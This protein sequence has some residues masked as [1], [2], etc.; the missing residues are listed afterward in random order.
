VIY[1]LIAVCLLFVMGYIYGV[2]NQNRYYLT[3]PI[4]PLHYTSR[5]MMHATRLAEVKKLKDPLNGQP[6]GL[7]GLTI[8]EMAEFSGTLYAENGARVVGAA[9]FGDRA[10]LGERSYVGDG[11]HIG[12]YAWVGENSIVLAGAHIGSLAIIGS[13]TV[14]GENVVLPNGAYV[15]PDVVVPSSETVMILGEFGP[16]RLI[17][18]VYGS[19]DGPRCSLGQ[20][21]GESL[22]MMA[23]RITHRVEVAGADAQVVERY[24][25]V[26]PL[27]GFAVQGYY[28]AQRDTVNALFEEAA[29]IRAS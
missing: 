1:A 5:H 18:T 14:V 7:E 22:Q 20:H 26:I 29:A 24:L 27:I 13:G 10:R 19:N 12:P 8:D 9:I 21:T 3:A 16:S 28:D 15:G 11:A 4:P 25:G 17:M 2:L 23:D 6:R